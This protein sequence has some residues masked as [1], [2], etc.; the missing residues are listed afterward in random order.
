V[1]LSVPD[2]GHVVLAVEGQ[3]ERTIALADIA[4]ATLVVDWT[5]IR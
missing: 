2:A 5:R 3:G 4:E 1:V